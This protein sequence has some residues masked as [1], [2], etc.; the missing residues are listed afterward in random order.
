MARLLALTA[1]SMLALVPERPVAAADGCPEI[2]QAYFGSRAPQACSV[3]FCE[4]TWRSWAISP[5][6]QN[7]G[8][9]QI[10]VIHGWRASTDPETNVAYAYELSQGGYDWSAWSCQP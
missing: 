6:G 1:L 2:I 4:S 9:F 10:N 8:L 3:S 7:I 5:D